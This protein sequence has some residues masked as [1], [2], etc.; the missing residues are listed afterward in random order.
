MTREEKEN[1]LIKNRLFIYQHIH[2]N[3]PK[4]NHIFKDLFLAAETAVFDAL[5]KYIPSKGTLTT[6][7]APYIRHGVSTYI[8]ENIY[9]VSAYYYHTMAKISNYI[10]LYENIDIN[11]FNDTNSFI[12]TDPLIKRISEYTHLSKKTIK[13][14]LSICRVN[15]PRFYDSTQDF[16]N[17]ISVS[18]H[19][20]S[21]VHKEDIDTALSELTNMDRQII[22]LKFGLDDEQPMADKAIAQKLSRSPKTVNS[23]LKQCFKMLKINPALKKYSGV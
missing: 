23:R 7:M 13:N 4:F 20:D 18:N 3:F 9:N 22:S 11:C 2:Q 1:I 17:Q 5:D 6:F 14:T 16:T 15:N 19:K 10:N 21:Y 12:D 8:A